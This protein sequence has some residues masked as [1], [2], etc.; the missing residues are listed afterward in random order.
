M[1]KFYVTRTR[2][3]RAGHIF[4][5]FIYSL[6]AIRDSRHFQKIFN[7]LTFSGLSENAS[8]ICRNPASASYTSVVA[9]AVEWELNDGRIRIQIEMKSSRSCNHR[10]TKLNKTLV[11]ALTYRHRSDAMQT[12]DAPSVP[13]E[14]RPRGRSGQTTAAVGRSRREAGETEDTGTTRTTARRDRGERIRR[15]E[16]ARRRLAADRR[17]LRGEATTLP[18]PATSPPAGPTG[19]N[20]GRPQARQ[21]SGYPPPV[22]LLRRRLMPPSEWRSDAVM[23]RTALTTSTRKTDA[24]R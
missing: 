24:Q 5:T 20:R 21:A 7:G 19:R 13:A 2:Y 8:H 17:Q 18:R 9:S 16:E 10:I 14:V 15:S 1:I 3:H 22:R 23:T 11:S 12:Q 4:I 6:S